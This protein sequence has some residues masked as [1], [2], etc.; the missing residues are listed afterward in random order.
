MSLT[1]ITLAQIQG[2]LRAPKGQHNKF[3]GYNYRSCEDVLEALKPILRNHDSAVI[4]SDSI[5]P[6]GEAIYVKATATLHTPDG[7]VDS[8]GWAQ[9]G[10]L[11]GM[12]P[13]QCTGAASSYARK[14][15]LNGLFAIDDNKD[16]DAVNTHGE[17]KKPVKEP[18][19]KEVKKEVKKEPAK[20]E[21]VDG[22]WK[23]F[24]IPFGKNKDKP[25][26]DL[27]D[28][29]LQWYIEN[30]DGKKADFRAALDA[31]AA[32]VNKE[33]EEAKTPNK[34]EELPFG[35]DGGEEDELPF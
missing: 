21:D 19:K 11:K 15:A 31:A 4:I 35:A 29:S 8:V 32:E 12:S 27:S 33:S 24:K 25:L 26:K 14:Y 7:H 6:I 34:V 16:A 23:E 1:T 20:K 10:S 9:E 5:E 2:E 28:Q 17:A 22:D 3:G 13:S 18:A 30:I